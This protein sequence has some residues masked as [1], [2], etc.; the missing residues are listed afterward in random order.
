MKIKK[1]RVLTS[2][3]LLCAISLSYAAVVDPTTSNKELMFNVATRATRDITSFTWNWLLRPT[4]KILKDNPFSS[5][6]ILAT[7][8]L[9]YN[10]RLLEQFK[11]IQKRYKDI[12]DQLKYL[13]DFYMKQFS[14]QTVPESYRNPTLE[15]VMNNL[16]VDIQNP[17]NNARAIENL[18]EWN[19]HPN[20][21]RML[22]SNYSNVPYQESNVA[23]PWITKLYEALNNNV[24]N[25]FKNAE[26]RSFTTKLYEPI[27]IAPTIYKSLDELRYPRALYLEQIQ[28]DIKTLEFIPKFLLLMPFK[29]MTYGQNQR[30]ISG[31]KEILDNRSLELMTEQLKLIAKMLSEEKGVSK[32]VTDLEALREKKKK[33]QQAAAAARTKNK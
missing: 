14:A 7:A 13:Y 25:T 4:L 32:E 1:Q 28:K 33:A 6:A 30:P 31:W 21:Y 23:V 18:K 12:T 16:L 10:Y 22:N 2:I 3:S 11:D 15:T 29:S 9:T 26:K 8:L 20:I 5:F 19:Q 24:Q 17:E 27:Q